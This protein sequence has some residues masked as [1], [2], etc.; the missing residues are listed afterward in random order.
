MS[1]PLHSIDQALAAQAA[2]C[3][4]LGSPL[5]GRVLRGLAADVTAGGLT[6]ELLC[7]RGFDRPLHDA[8]PLRLLGAVHRI[9]LRGAAPVL[10]AHYPSAGGV[11]DG[12]DP[13]P[14]VLATMAAHRAEVEAGLWRNVQTNEVGR[15]A[16]LAVGFAAV[17]DRHRLPLRLFELGSSSG[18]NL[19]WDRYWY[20]TGASSMGDARS[21]VRFEGV[22]EEP[23]PVFSPDVHVAARAGC[24]VA[25]LDPTSPDDRLTLLSFVWPDQAARFERLRAALAIAAEVPAPVAAADAGA[26]L[27]ARL[28]E[29]ADGVTTVV[30]HSI[31]WQYLPAAS[32]TAARDA[33]TA[34]GARASDAAPLAWLR[35]EPAGPVAGLRLTTWPGGED[36]LL[37]TSSY[38]GPPVVPS[39]DLSG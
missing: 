1:E 10:A 28:A 4:A 30:F 24:D 5:Y 31:V 15:C 12:A 7:D 14:D 35:L 6:A 13:T 19:R 39:S 27:T 22:W 21:A 23:L 34:A 33:L 37:A 29:R 20:D 17:H 9:V 2:A 26:W 38:H 32:K 3:D 11:D 25:P 16:A 18:L 36:R 8:V